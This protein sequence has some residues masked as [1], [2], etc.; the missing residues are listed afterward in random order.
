MTSFVAKSLLLTKL[1]EKKRKD[2]FT[3]V[4][5]LVVVI[6]VGILSSVALPAFLNQAAKAKIASAKSLAASGAKECQ[7]YMVDNTGTWELTTNGSD[8]I[9]F[10]GATDGVCSATAGG[11][12]SALI[13][14]STEFIAVVDNKG[15]VD[16]TC[17]LGAGDTAA[18][19]EVA[20]CTFETDADVTAAVGEW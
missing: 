1:Q 4:E 8:G 3:L 11:T 19:G 2:G 13:K 12:Y 14:D 15:K 16:K 18:V 20:G 5:L 10:P 9:T 7:A 6:I 17:K